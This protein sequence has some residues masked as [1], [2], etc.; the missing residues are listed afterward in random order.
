MAAAAHP[1]ALATLDGNEAAARVAYGLS[2][3][4]A[5]YPITPSSAMAEHADAWAAA[6]RP[7]VFGDVP[8][9]IQMQSEAGAAGALHGERACCRSS[10]RRLNRHLRA[11]LERRGALRCP[12]SSKFTRAPRPSATAVINR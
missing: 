3:V 11:Q 7:N 1:A 9:V 5:I 2:E 12:P 10:A 6:G 4:I 8:E